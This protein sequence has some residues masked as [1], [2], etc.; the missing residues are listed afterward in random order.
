MRRRGGNNERRNGDQAHAVA[1]HR[2]PLL[3]RTASW[4]IGCHCDKTMQSGGNGESEQR[5]IKGVAE[6][7]HHPARL[8]TQSRITREPPATVTFLHSVLPANAMRHKHWRKDHASSYFIAFLLGLALLPFFDA[9]DGLKFP[10]CRK[11]CARG[12]PI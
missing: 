4:R 7:S 11:T 3:L 2:S 5:F 12:L 8:H 1:R 9:G 6:L 10:I